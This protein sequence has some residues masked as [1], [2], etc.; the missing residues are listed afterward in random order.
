MRLFIWIKSICFLSCGSEQEK[1]DMKGDDKKGVGGDEKKDIEF[2]SQEDLKEDQ[3][4]S[5]P[6]RWLGLLV[7]S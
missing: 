3:Q 7:L 4:S 5:T 1:E 2:V 6:C